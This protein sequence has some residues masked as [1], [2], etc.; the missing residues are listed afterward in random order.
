M[1]VPKQDGEQRA[2]IAVVPKRRQ[3]GTWFS[4]AGSAVALVVSGVSLWE[5][6]L[7]LP[8]LKVYVGDTISY[9]RD[10]WGSYEVF[11]IPIT[12]TNSGAREGALMSM[13]LAVKNE[14]S[15]GAEVF[16]SS[17]F[18]DATWFSGNDNV[19]NRTKRPKAPF[20]PMSIA[21]RSSWTGT[22]LFY[23]PEWKEKKVVDPGSRLSA[24]MT[25]A[26]PAARRAG[27]SA[28]SSRSC[29]MPFR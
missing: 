7:K 26:D 4:T 19:A 21:G 28:H 6:T 13:R 11:V 23:P 5:T 17:Y 2:A 10:P 9:T 25:V 3:I 8:S 29:R 18:A 24:V 22:L 1:T 15:G 16:E 20:A 14:A 27:S 12:I